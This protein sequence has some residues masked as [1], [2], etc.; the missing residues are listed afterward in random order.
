MSKKLVG[1]LALPILLALGISII[2]PN[3]LNASETKIVSQQQKSKKAI[4]VPTKAQLAQGLTSTDGNFLA[5]TQKPDK[6]WTNKKLQ[7]YNLPDKSSKTISIKLDQLFNLSSWSP[8]SAYL[9]IYEESGYYGGLKGHVID[10][11]KNKIISTFPTLNPEIVW[12]DDSSFYYFEP[13]DDCIQGICETQKS[14]HLKLM[15][16][17][18]IK[19][20]FIAKFSSSEKFPLITNASLV[21]DKLQFGYAEEYFDYTSKATKA[22]QVDASTNE[23]EEITVEDLMSLADDTK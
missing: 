20:N 23:I 4:S 8:N 9:Y 21:N 3:I 12:V 18:T 16:L 22:Y 6:S 15:N 10:V 5:Y 14:V 2:H 11:Q 7:I 1:L 13:Q 19:P 17:D